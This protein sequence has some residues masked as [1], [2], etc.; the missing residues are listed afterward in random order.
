MLKVKRE[1]YGGG[2]KVRSR[3]ARDSE[4]PS[5][6]RSRGNALR[7]NDDVFDLNKALEIAWQELMLAGGGDTLDY[8]GFCRGLDRM[9]CPEDSNLR[10]AMFA[11]IDMD[12]N[13]VITRND[14]ADEILDLWTAFKVWCAGAFKTA[15]NLQAHLN[16][17]TE[18][19][20]TAY[21]R[22]LGWHGAFE[23]VLLGI[24]TGARNS[25]GMAFSQDGGF[26]GET[27]T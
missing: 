11:D 27:G 17:R 19:E 24:L 15:S 2:H 21:L 13:G 25:A 23:P 10:K 22:I 18:A 14:L 3:K 8:E 4:M 7:Q 1:S 5:G 26:T 6:E 12:S 16:G 20:L 9:G